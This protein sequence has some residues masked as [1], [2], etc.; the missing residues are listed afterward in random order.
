MTTQGRLDDRIAVVTGA[1]SGLGFAIAMRLAEVGAVVVVADLDGAAADAAATTIARETGASAQAIPH[2]VTS[3]AS[4]EAMAATVLREQGRIDVLVNN[5]G[6][7][8]TVPFLDMSEEEWDRVHDVNL[9]GVFLV[10][11]AVAPVMARQRSGRIVNIS[12]MV[13]KESE[14]E[15]LHY[16]S[17]KAAVISLTQGLARELAS[18]DLNVNAVCPGIIRTPL[19]EPKLDDLAALHGIDREEAF[20]QY[21]ARIPLGRPQEPEDVAAMVAFLASDL[22]RNITGQAINVCGGAQV[23]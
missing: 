13:G 7:A 5:A 16:C 4:C 20:A 22:A 14:P 2:D 23:H 9:K 1:A 10:T 15:S 8:A 12:S 17:A 11:R 19:W 3:R 21:V 18:Y 6:I